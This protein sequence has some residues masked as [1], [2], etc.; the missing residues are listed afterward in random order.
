MK[1]A[2]KFFFILSIWITCM[3]VAGQNRPD[4][5]LSDSVRLAEYV[6]LNIHYPLMDLINKV[7]GTA[8][9]RFEYDSLMRVHTIKTLKSSGSGSLDREGI[10][11]LRQVPKQGNEYPKHEISVSFRLADNKIYDLSEVIGE[12]IP[13]FP[14]GVAEMH[15]FISNNYVWP[16]EGAEMSVSGNILCGCVIEKD[17][18][19]HIVEVVRSLDRWFDAEAVRVIKRMPKW[20]AGKKDGKPVRVYY[21][22]PVRISLQL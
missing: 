7:E 15:K 19:I 8:V 13:E 16:R 9:Y 3:N 20:K 12:E 5:I 10:R 18:S 11:L 21:I 1:Q 14:G 6:Y 2:A 4:D 17:G 22:V